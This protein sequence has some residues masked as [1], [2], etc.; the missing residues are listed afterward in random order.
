MLCAHN[1]ATVQPQ[2]IRRI[3]LPFLMAYLP[4]VFEMKNEPTEQI[5]TNTYTCRYICYHIPT[6][7]KASNEDMNRYT[8]SIRT[9]KGKQQ[10]TAACYYVSGTRLCVRHHEFHMLCHHFDIHIMLP[11]NHRHYHGIINGK[12]QMHEHWT[13]YIH[14]NNNSKVNDNRD[15]NVCKSATA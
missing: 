4:N 15:G 2:P 1:I 5:I 7:S 11:L 13:M 14:A 3:I 6:F 9:L 12:E 10:A 8:L